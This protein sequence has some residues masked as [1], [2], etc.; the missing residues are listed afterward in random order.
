MYSGQDGLVIYIEM[1]HGESRT[2]FPNELV[3]EHTSTCG[4]RSLRPGQLRRVQER[5]KKEELKLG[6]LFREC[7]KEEDEEDEEEH[8][9]RKQ[10]FLVGKRKDGSRERVETVVCSDVWL[11][12]HFAFCADGQMSPFPRR[13]TMGG[14][15]SEV[16]Q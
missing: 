15:I 5:N 3:V 9:E 11:F 12:A 13:K 6:T 16:R 8:G 4:S 2:F 10:T 1:F 14:G 7:F